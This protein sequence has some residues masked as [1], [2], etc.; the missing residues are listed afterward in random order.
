MTSCHHGH[1]RFENNLHHA[2]RVMNTQ[3][4]IRVLEIDFVH[5][6]DDFIS[7]H[8]YK[9]ENVESGSSIAEWVEEVIIKRDKILWI[10]IKS[11]IDPIAFMFV[12]CDMR[13]KFDC[14]HLFKVLATLCNKT[15]RRLQDN[16]WL[17]CQDSEVQESLLRLNR[18]LKGN[19]KWTIVTDMPF[20]YSYACKYLNEWLPLGLSTR[21][22]DYVVSYFLDY[23]FGGVTTGFT[24]VIVCIDHTF[25]P[26]DASLIQFV[27]N[28]TIPPGAIIVLYTYERTHPRIKIMGY[29]V[30]MQYDYTTAQMRRKPRQPLLGDGETSTVNNNKTHSL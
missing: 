14:R 23:D 3:S 15:R 26:S 2:V 6:G 12:C 18:T 5:V 11:H 8:D 17:S 1:A 4:E 28:S 22:H 30:I 19:L 13:F 24:D 29:E 10:D 16:V 9:A 21:I 7:S 27:E 25:F 20:V